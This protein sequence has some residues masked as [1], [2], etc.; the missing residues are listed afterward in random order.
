MTSTRERDSSARKVNVVFL[1]VSFHCLFLEAQDQ[2][3]PG[4][5]PDRFPPFQGNRSN[6]LLQIN[7]FSVYYVKENF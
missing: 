5:D 6:F 4:A 7:I 3:N 2:T 1:Y